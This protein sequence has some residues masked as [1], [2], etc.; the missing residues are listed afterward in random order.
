MK[1]IFVTGTDTGVGKTLISCLLMEFFLNKGKD[2]I[3]LKI[4]QTGCDSVFHPD[5][6]PFFVY[7]NLYK[8]VDRS[9]LE[10]KICYLF[11][12]PKA[13]YFAALDAGRKIDIDYVFSWIE[14]TKVDHCPVILEG[15]GGLMVPVLR[16]LLI[17]D[18]MERMD[19]EVILVARP[20]LGTINHTLLSIQAL[21]SRSIPIKAV[22]FSKNY[23]EDRDK[24]LIFENMRAIK[25]FSGIDVYLIGPIHTPSVDGQKY[26]VIWED[27]FHD[28]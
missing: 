27:L 22:I 5:C 14:E 13:P 19:I 9:F 2:P 1:D 23:I 18:L 8:D 11:E 4:F 15:A 17:I 7:K 3:Y 26:H 25:D 20:T 21:K 24:D 10:Q 6:D 16:D 12:N 28:L